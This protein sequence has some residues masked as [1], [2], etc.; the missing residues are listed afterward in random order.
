MTGSRMGMAESTVRLLTHDAA[1]M[2]RP[3]ATDRHHHAFWQLDHCAGG[4]IIAW[5]PQ[6]SVHLRLGEGLLLPPGQGHAFRYPRGACYVSWKFTWSGPGPAG[7]VHL[8]SQPGWRGVAAALAA[9]PVAAARPHLLTAA[10]RIA[11]APPPA[12]GFAARLISLVDAHPTRIWSV[13]ALARCLA[14]SPGHVSA[15]FRVEHG[16]ALKRW[17]DVRRAETAARMLAGSDLGIAHIADACGFSDQFAFSRF[18]R[19]IT[20]T[21]PSAFRAR[22][23]RFNRP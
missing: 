7:A 14:L 20:S 13:A 23:G 6:G 1:R 9:A 11:G 16:I 10:M 3:S 15:R 22:Q 5:T 2:Q 4:A 12:T 21:S 19:R 17:L 8:A 18:F